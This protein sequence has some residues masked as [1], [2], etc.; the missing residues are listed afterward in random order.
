MKIAMSCFDFF[1]IS[2][3]RY[4]IREVQKCS[5]SQD[6]RIVKELT[7]EM[8]VKP[9]QILTLQRLKGGWGGGD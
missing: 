9:P 8:G 6:P 1:F 2:R 7:A 3:K 5:F 4:L